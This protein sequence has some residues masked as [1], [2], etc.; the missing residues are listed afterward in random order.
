MKG[1]LAVYRKE[2]ADQ[3]S[4]YRF[5][6]LFALIAMVSLITTYMAGIS[7]R[8]S[9]EGTVKPKFVFLMLFNTT[10]ALFSLV[11]FV[12]FFGPLIGLVMG[13]D[14]IN[15]E[16]AQGTL[17]KIISQPIYRDAVIN[18]KFLAGVTTITI[19]LAAIV[20]TITGFGLTLLGIVPGVEE[21]ARLLIYLIIS[22]CY[23][24]FW[25]GVA[26]LFSIV[27][28]SVAT[29]A[30]AAVALWIFLSFFVSLGASVLANAVASS[31]DNN[32]ASTELLLKRAK[33]KENISLLSPMVLYS[34]ASATIIDPMRNTTKSLVL[35]GPL[36][37]L[38]SSRFQNPL[39]LDQSVLVVYPHLVALVAITLLCFAI[40]YLV[41]MTQEIR[42]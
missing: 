2:L 16:R 25:L 3:F 41:F 17:I 5:M 35:M 23:I 40:S 27:F 19:M 42:S 18:G 26:I 10:G 20:L 28:K 24:S 22:I 36:E 9:L 15:R 29:S 11:Q 33:L 30:L 12:A 13:F 6:I 7:L 37:R 39:S 4:S 14:A 8:E 21:L 32:Q 38:S 1:L 31:H 34:N